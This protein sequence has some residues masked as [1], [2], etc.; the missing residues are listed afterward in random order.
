VGTVSGSWE[1]P[2]ARGALG[3]LLLGRLPAAEERELRAHL[4]RCPGCERE[5]RELEPV[6]ALLARAD[7]DAVDR[8]DRLR[9]VGSAGEG[10]A[11][12][13]PW[14]PSAPPHLRHAVLSALAV[15]GQRSRRRRAL[16]V[17]V[18]SAV[19]AALAAL[20]LLV[21]VPGLGGSP[22]AGETR[23]F[24]AVAGSG[25]SGSVTVHQKAG[26]TV[27]EIRAQGMRV[28]EVYGFWLE[29]RD[30]SRVGAGR[31]TAYDTTC[32]LVLQAPVPLGAAEAVGFTTVDDHVDVARA[33][34]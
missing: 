23:Q 16:V 4:A 14:S 22:A 10:T 28:G 27:L 17:A 20:L 19:A 7:P 2:A 24:V 26:G 9:G 31:W 3:A 6:V 5:R 18:P 1:C 8:E 29:R 13:G 12:E 15:E 25:A 34:L 33:D 32:H 11:G 30:G 21:G